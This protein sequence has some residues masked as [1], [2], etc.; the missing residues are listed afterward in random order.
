MILFKNLVSLEIKFTPIVVKLS[1]ILRSFISAAIWVP[2]FI[3]PSR[4][5]Y[6]DADQAAPDNANKLSP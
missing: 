2:Y 5:C 4:Y 3:R 1:A 6:Q